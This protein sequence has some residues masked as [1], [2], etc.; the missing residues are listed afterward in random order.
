MSLEKVVA[1][2]IDI[3]RGMEYIHAQGI[4]HRDL[5]P[6]NVLIDG[7]SNLKIADFG[8]ACETAKYDSL[9][10]TYRWMAPE[11]IKGKRYGR[12]VAVA[13]AHKNSRPVIPFNYC[14]TILKDLIKQCWA[15]EPKKRPEFRRVVQVLEQIE[16]SLRIRY[17]RNPESGAKI[18]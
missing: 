13:V 3:C 16:Q 1:F 11:M 14:P 2:A 10:G 4:I 9:S 5:K 7:E 6:E 18:L 8:I 17:S 12:K 15:L